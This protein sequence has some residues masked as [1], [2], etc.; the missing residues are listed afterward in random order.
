M[1][2]RLQLSGG[3]GQDVERSLII[4]LAEGGTQATLI[5]SE[6]RICFGDEGKLVV[7]PRESHHWFGDEGILDCV[8]SLEGFLVD[9][10]IFVHV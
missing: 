3:I 8:E 7:G 1:L 2:V 4:D 9:W 6:C 5:V 10:A